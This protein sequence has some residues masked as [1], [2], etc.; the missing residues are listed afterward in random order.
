M[1]VLR[2]ILT[3]FQWV[4]FLSLMVIV[5]YLAYINVGAY[6]RVL[7]NL[8]AASALAIWIG[9]AAFWLIQ[10]NEI[11]PIVMEKLHNKAAELLDFAEKAKDKDKDLKPLVVQLKEEQ[12]IRH[13]RLIR[14]KWLALVFTGIDLLLCVLFLFTPIIKPG[15]SLGTVILTM[16]P[17]LIVWENV[18]KT[19]GTVW[20]IPLAVKLAVEESSDGFPNLGQLVD[21][22]KSRFQ[23]S[24]SDSGSDSGSG[25]TTADPESDPAKASDTSK[26][27]KS[28]TASL[29][30]STPRFYV[31]PYT[32]S[33]SSSSSPASS[34]S[35]PT[36]T[37][38]GKTVPH[39]G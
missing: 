38:N 3:I 24:A 29:P 30:R 16:N 22:L 31:V 1:R 21:S 39:A 37:P 34:P 26:S 27:G 19:L 18:W 4:I 20:L 35:S 11:R 7:I 8:G 28:R 32:A 2:L 6:E 15:V 10:A 13:K 36:E 14:A 17:G 33:S 25:S 23:P 5:A 9:I 12:A